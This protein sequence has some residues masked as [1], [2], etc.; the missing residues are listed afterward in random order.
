MYVCLALSW[1]ASDLMFLF[2]QPMKRMVTIQMVVLIFPLRHKSRLKEML[3]YSVSI[4]CF[5]VSRG[6]RGGRGGSYRQ[7]TSLIPLVV[8]FF[9]CMQMPHWLVLVSAFLLQALITHSHAF[10]HV[11]FFLWPKHC[12]LN[13]HTL[14]LQWV[15]VGL[16]LGWKSW[17]SISRLLWLCRPPD[18]FDCSQCGFWVRIA[19][20]WLV[21]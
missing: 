12:K 16:H 5:S 14:A 4:F 18:K 11:L 6:R 21:F 20:N 7:G 17:G 8:G 19:V 15:H 13:V 1:N 2:L 10:I 9:H 3:V